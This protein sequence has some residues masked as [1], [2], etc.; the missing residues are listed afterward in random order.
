MRCHSHAGLEWDFEFLLPG[1]RLV[2][3]KTSQDESV[4]YLFVTSITTVRLRD[5]GTE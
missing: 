1:P 3:F 2:G 5:V 4:V